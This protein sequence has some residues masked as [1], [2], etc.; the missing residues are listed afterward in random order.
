ME[1]YMQ[2]GSVSFSFF[3]RIWGG[4]VFSFKCSVEFASETL[5]FQAFTVVIVVGMFF[6]YWW[7]LITNLCISSWFISGSVHV[8]RNLSI[9]S[10]LFNLLTYIQQSIVLC[11]FCWSLQRTNFGFYWF[12]SIFFPVSIS[13]TSALILIISLLLF[14]LDLIFSFF[15]IS[16]VEN[17]DYWFYILL[18]FYYQSNLCWMGNTLNQ[19]FRILLSFHF[20]W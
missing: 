13:L 18:F 9:L 8:S 12:F 4:S 16:K 3:G 5:L 19:D 20:L 7:N 10:R 2:F 1:T 17:K 6:D 15:I 11:Q 14:G